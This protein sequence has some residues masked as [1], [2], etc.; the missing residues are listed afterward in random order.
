[1]LR[2]AVLVMAL[3][4]AVAPATVGCD[5]EPDGECVGV[6]CAPC[7]YP[8]TL[9]VLDFD[10][11]PLAARITIEEEPEIDVEC[12]AGQSESC[13]VGPLE[14]GQYTAVVQSEGYET[15]TM[16]V[17]LSEPLGDPSDCCRCPVQ[18]VQLRVFLRPGAGS[19]APPDAGSDGG[20]DPDG[21]GGAP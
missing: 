7:P 20:G 15:A 9:E 12:A 11:M 16:T 17:T 8:L 19:G 4:A 3:S 18:E 21:D 10:E 13:G 6:E 14:P 5:D 1:M 2:G